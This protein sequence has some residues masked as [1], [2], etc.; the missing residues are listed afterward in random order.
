MKDKDG[1][2]P[3]QRKERY[4]VVAVPELQKLPASYCH[5]QDCQHWMLYVLH[6]TRQS[7]H[8]MI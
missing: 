2:T 1:L 3:E 8:C 7:H 6:I 5:T 4:A